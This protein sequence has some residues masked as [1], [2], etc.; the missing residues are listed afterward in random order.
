MMLQTGVGGG[1]SGEQ[2]SLHLWGWK[3]NV[4]PKLWHLP[5]S[6][7]G[8][9]TQNNKNVSPTRRKHKIS[10]E[11]Y[12]SWSISARIF[13][14]HLADRRSNFRSAAVFCGLSRKTKSGRPRGNGT[15]EEQTTWPEMSFAITLIIYPETKNFWKIHHLSPPHR[16]VNKDLEPPPPTHPT[17]FLRSTNT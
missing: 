4:P 9:K 3:Q 17:F 15:K 12:S 2:H 14:A 1:A 5:T 13:P 8:A 6:L 7:H 16:N 10:Q 11:L